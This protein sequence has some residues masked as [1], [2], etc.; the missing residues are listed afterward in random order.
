MSVTLSD[1]DKLLSSEE[2]AE[3][4]GTTVGTLATWRSTKRY[5]LR[6]VKIGRKVRYRMSDVIQWIESRTQDGNQ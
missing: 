5:D 1:P 2:T 6:W 4:L 3:F